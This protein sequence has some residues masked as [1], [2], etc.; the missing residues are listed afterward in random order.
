MC[1][2]A[3][4]LRTGSRFRYGATVCIGPLSRKGQ[5]ARFFPVR[6]QC[7][8]DTPGEW[9]FAERLKDDYLCWSK[10]PVGAQGRLSGFRRASSSSRRPH[11]LV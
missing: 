11:A 9:D 10:V 7:Q 3:Q 6:S 4:Q 1:H 8:F 2:H 5:M